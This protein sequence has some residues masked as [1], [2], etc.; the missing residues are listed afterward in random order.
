MLP[1]KSI[2]GL[3]ASDLE[4]ITN[5]IFICFIV[6]FIVL[7]INGCAG[8]TSAPEF[9]TVET[10]ILQLNTTLQDSYALGVLSTATI[11]R[12]K[13]SPKDATRKIPLTDPSMQHNVC[14]SPDD[15]GLIEAW[16]IKTKTWVQDHCQN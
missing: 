12:Q 8:L 7:T 15:E 14:Y 9:P 10:R 5:L 16:V 11:Q 13:L 6:L 2:R 4:Q 1:K 3:R